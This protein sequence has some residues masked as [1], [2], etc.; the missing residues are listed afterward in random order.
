M[1]SRLA[2]KAVIVMGSRVKNFTD[3][4]RRDLEAFVRKWMKEHVGVLDFDPRFSDDPEDPPVRYEIYD[5]LGYTCSRLPNALY[6][7]NKGKLSW[8]NF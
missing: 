2:Y 6:R 4:N 5:R 8:G 1:S 7:N 3:P